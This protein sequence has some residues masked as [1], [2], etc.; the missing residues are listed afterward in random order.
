MEKLRVINQDSK[1]NW[2]R[3]QKW[4]EAIRPAGRAARGWIRRLR[5]NAANTVRNAPYWRRVGPD[6]LPIPPDR[7]M[8]LVAGTPDIAWFLRSGA[9]GAQS[10]R[11]ILQQNAIALEKAEAILDFGCGC[12]RVIRYWKDLKNTRVHG[13][14]Y[15]PLLVEWCS[16]NLPFAQFDQNELAPP[17]KYAD[18][19]FDLIYALSV[20][21]H[22]SED[23]H[24]QWVNELY[25]VLKPGGTLFLSIRTFIDTDNW[26]DQEKAAFDAGKLVVRS[27]DLAG[28]NICNTFHPES[29]VHQVFSQMFDVVALV[30]H[31][32]RGNTPQDALL[33]RKPVEAKQAVTAI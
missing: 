24:G 7:L 22:L 13:T 31:G 17:L 19:S 10:L 33:L 16:K 15:N 23:L 29:Y 20:F 6:N 18:D 26:P 5:K 32:A 27:E 4:F 12:G 28:S 21:T 1:G 2:L 30:P 8:Y 25:R 9:M 3:S 14:D 11:E